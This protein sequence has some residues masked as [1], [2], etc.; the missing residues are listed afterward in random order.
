MAKK[1]SRKKSRSN[2]LSR[3]DNAAGLDNNTR[4]GL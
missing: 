2:T 1:K 4:V 3:F